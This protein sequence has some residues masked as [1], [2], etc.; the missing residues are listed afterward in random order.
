MITRQN[1]ELDKPTGSGNNFSGLF[2]IRRTGLEFG[3]Q[4]ALRLGLGIVL[5]PGLKIRTQFEQEITT[6]AIAEGACVIQP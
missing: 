6:G 5:D 1:D 4:L 2:Y 3:L